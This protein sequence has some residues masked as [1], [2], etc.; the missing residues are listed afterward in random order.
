MCK[1]QTQQTLLL[2]SN[3]TAV[4]PSTPVS[5]AAEDSPSNIVD[6]WK[7]SGKC[8]PP[9]HAC[10]H[11]NPHSP[12][13]QKES[14]LKKALHLLAEEYLELFFFNCMTFG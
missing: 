8:V 6:G 7:V 5:A 10:A 2:V 13:P 1:A 9:A 12:T 11:S 14:K 3:L 4:N